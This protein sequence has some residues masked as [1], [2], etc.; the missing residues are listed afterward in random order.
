MEVQKFLGKKLSSDAELINWL[1]PEDKK[2]VDSKQ[3]KFPFVHLY[4]KLKEKDY[5]KLIKTAKQCE[6]FFRHKC[7][8]EYINKYCLNCSQKNFHPNDLIRFINFETFLYYMKYMFYISNNIVAY[9]KE[10]FNKNKNDFENIINDSKELKE[11]F[12][13]DGAKVLCK[14]CMFKLINKP[15]F[16]ENIKK[17]LSR[18]KPIFEANFQIELNEES[19]IDGFNNEKS[20]NLSKDKNIIILNLGEKNKKQI[21]KNDSNSN[22]IINYNNTSNKIFNTVIFNN[23]STTFPIYENISNINIGKINPNYIKS[24]FISCKNEISNVLNT[25]ELYLLK[26]IN[27]IDCLSK[28]QLI[29]NKLNVNFTYLVNSIKTNLNHI[30]LLIKQN[31]ILEYNT[32]VVFFIFNSKIILDLLNRLYFVFL[33]IENIF[34]RYVN[35]DN[36]SNSICK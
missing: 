1:S 22:I 23:N 28:I 29:N 26:Q 27:D 15:N 24:H 13:F 18:N 5:D 6:L 34:I 20:N 8:N 14:Q 10:N 12:K 21:I 17:I 4:Y 33:D 9:S 7:K 11:K 35:D 32:Y 31:G 3:L 16:F 19:D 36:S 2:E 25:F 30:N